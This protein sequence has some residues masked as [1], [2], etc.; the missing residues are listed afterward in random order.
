MV[1]PSTQTRD[2]HAKLDGYF[3]I[4]S[5]AH[6]LVVIP[7]GQRVVHYR[8]RIDADPEATVLS[9]GVLSLDPPGLTVAVEGLFPRCAETRPTMTFP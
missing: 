9:A 2:T 8:R 3:R 1:S 5:V 7:Q 4:A 6:Y